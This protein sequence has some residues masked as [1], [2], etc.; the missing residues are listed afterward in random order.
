M[1]LSD[2]QRA[3]RCIGVLSDSQMGR[4]VLV[5]LSDSQRG[6]RCTGAFI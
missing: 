1:F 2:S 6:Q 3:K 4:G 5:F